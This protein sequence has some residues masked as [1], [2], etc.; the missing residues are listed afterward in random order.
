VQL[1]E[2]S[3]ITAHFAENSGQAFI[4]IFS[5]KDFK[6]T[7]A[8]QICNSY[9]SPSNIVTKLINRGKNLII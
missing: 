4:D 1:I 7:K 9:F 5:C 6:E 3:N 2:T 8:L